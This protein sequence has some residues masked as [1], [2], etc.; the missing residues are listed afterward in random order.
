MNNAPV[1]PN[2][3]V[4][5]NHKEYSPSVEVLDADIDD[6]DQ[7]MG[8][9]E[10]LDVGKNIE[11]KTDPRNVDAYSS[12]GGILKMPS[13]ALISQA[14]ESKEYFFRL[15]KLNDAVNGFIWGCYDFSADS[16]FYES[17]MRDGVV[18]QDYQIFEQYQLQDLV[19]YGM[20]LMIRPDSQRGALGGLLYYLYVKEL[21]KRGLSKI[22]FM[23]EKLGSL[24]SEGGAITELDMNNEA[25]LGLHAL[26][27]ATM[28]KRI[29]DEVDAGDGYVAKRTCMYHMV[30]VDYVLKV[31][32]SK[33][34]VDVS[35]PKNDSL[36]NMRRNLVSRTADM[37]KDL[38]MIR[39]IWDF[40]MRAQPRDGERVFT[41][42]GYLVATAGLGASFRF[43]D[44]SESIDGLIGQDGRHVIT[45]DVALNVAIIDACFASVL[46]EA[47]EKFVISDDTVLKASQRASIVAGEVQRVSE[48]YSMTHAKVLMIG[49][50]QTI[51]EEMV[52]RGLSPILSDMDPELLD[53]ENVDGNAI[54][55]GDQNGLLIPQSDIV[56]ATG[57]T[58]ATSTFDEIFA[59][60]KKWHKPVVIFAQTGSNLADEYIGLGVETVISEHYP[61]YCIPGV[62]AIEVFRMPNDASV[63]RGYTKDQVV[64]VIDVVGTP[65]Y[66][67][68]GQRIKDNATRL[69]SAFDGCRMY[70]SIKANPN[71]DVCSIIARLGYDAEVVTDGEMDVAIKSG[72]NPSS[73]LFAGPGKIHS[74]VNRAVSSGVR[75]FTAESVNQLKLLDEV[76]R[77]RNVVLKVL[78]RMNLPELYN[79][80][81]ESMM[82]KSSQFGLDVDSLISEKSAIDALTNIRIVGTQFYAASQILDPTKLAKSVKNQ[83]N[84]TRKIMGHI[85]M[86]LEILDV[87]GGFGIPYQ[88]GDKAL[89][90][91]SCAKL[92]K[93]AMIDAGSADIIVESGRYL[94]GDAGTFFTRVI[95]V[96]KSFDQYHVICDGGMVGFTRPMLVGQHHEVEL[97]THKASN[98]VRGVCTV[99]GFSCSSLDIFDTIEMDVPEVGDVIA[100]KNAGAYGWSMSIKDFHCA[101]P[102]SEF[103]LNK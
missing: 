61:W 86:T 6:L 55:N 59:M 46:K 93:E 10:Q 82:G 14:I 58:L 52:R 21:K 91:E 15:S 77:E 50:V 40:N 34:G 78:L 88:D 26:L 92:A 98:P 5:G 72:F 29:D 22:V 31:L 1:L 9:Y 103:V 30:D 44:S 53:Q 64:D 35:T 80:Q 38:F 8:I 100:V 66:I 90:L 67:Y 41:E 89:D 17:F 81:S 11:K 63:S 54:N 28:I 87:G 79:E 51:V 75:L 13:R 69:K 70:F 71:V 68:D 37:P 73:I 84:Q 56:L 20:D 27:G 60:A 45:D 62:S 19:A 49:V 101:K 65:V 57:M 39:G 33:L 76:A 2:G 43:Q 12:R 97:F 99:S 4:D 47:N 36:G 94:V 85:P 74:Q 18:T 48:K 25:T 7:I 3:S 83:L 32:G 96:K 23:I 24:I 42:S 16:P 95:D 102:P